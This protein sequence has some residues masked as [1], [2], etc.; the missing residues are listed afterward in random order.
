[1]P[2]YV[3]LIEASKFHTEEMRESVVETVQVY[4]PL[5]EQLPVIEINN[6]FT[7]TYNEEVSNNGS[8]IAFR[9]LNANYAP[10]VGMTIPKTESMAIF[11]GSA[12]VDEKTEQQY[13]GTMARE[14]RKK[15]K[16]MSL[17]FN[18]HFINGDVESDPKSFDGLK[19]RITASNTFSPAAP[20]DIS[21]SAANFLQFLELLDEAMDALFGEATHLFM[22]KTIRRKFTSGMRKAGVDVLGVEIDTLQRQQLTYRGARFAILDEDDQ[23]NQILPMTEGDSANT[24]SIY[25]VRLSD[26]DG[27]SGISNGGIGV[28]G[29]ERVSGTKQDRVQIEAMMGLVVLGKAG[30]RVSGIQ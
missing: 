20:L 16:S 26:L 1:M 13:P 25:P 12:D 9:A 30:A 17:F 8:G 3:T 5:I 4:S 6:G 21:A 2:Q 18:N 7:Y 14:T 22:N 19:K 23:G 29:P 27:I 15:L 28:D 10:S 11:G 24:C